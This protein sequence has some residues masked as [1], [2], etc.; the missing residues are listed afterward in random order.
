M[1]TLKGPNPELPEF[2]MTGLL[3]GLKHAEEK[4][5]VFLFTDAGAKDYYLSDSVIKE[6]Q[7]KQ[8]KVNFIIT[9]MVVSQSSSGNKPETVAV[10]H[11]IAQVSDG[12][13]FKIERNIM[14]DVLLWISQSLD[15]K[16]EALASIDSKTAGTTSAPVKVDS[17]F[18]KIS[19]SLSGSNS[20]LT[21]KDKNNQIVV[22]KGLSS[23]NIKFIT[24]DVV[25]TEYTIIA[26]SSS[27]YSIRVGG[28][29]DLKISFGFSTDVPSRMIE[30]AYRPLK[31]KQNILSVSVSDETLVKC[32]TNASLISAVE[33]D[34]FDVVDASFVSIQGGLYSSSLIDI[35]KKPFKIRIRGF[36]KNGNLI[37]RVISSSLN[38]IEGGE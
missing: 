15:S 19:V 7:K 3:A 27:A 17:T 34:P 30:T 20:E 12:Q 28:F 22:G 33:E 4:S 26:S 16:F 1:F 37:D 18:K 5:I 10:Y 8:V 35:P 36:D 9:N 38:S 29:S 32:L 11:K 14:K 24:F 31:D 25:D 23:G 21:V 2:S 6:V 13:V